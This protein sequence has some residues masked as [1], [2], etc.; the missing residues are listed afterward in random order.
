MELMNPVG[1]AEQ[2]RSPRYPVSLP[3]R[4]NLNP[5]FHYLQSIRKMGV[6]GKVENISGEGLM[7]DSQLDVGD[8]C[9]IFPEAMEE[10]STFEIELEIMDSRN[11][12]TLLKG[13]VRWYQLEERPGNLL[14]LKAGVHLRD[15]ESQAVAQDIV[16]YALEVSLN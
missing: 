15:K 2:R 12:K 9:Q 7:L 3:T 6:G 8:V 16:K 13:S 10:G 14:H 5:D 1:G 4:F 11:R